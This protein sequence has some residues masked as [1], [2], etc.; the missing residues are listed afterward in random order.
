MHYINRKIESS[1]LEY[2][3]IF[4][5]LGVTGPRQSG[6]STVL[7]YLLEKDYEY[8]TFDDPK[9]I[10]FFQDDPE[11]FFKRYA[12]HII[13]DEVQKVPELF[14]YIKLKV[15]NNRSEMGQFIL[16]GSSQFSLLK[17][18]TES[19]AGRIGLLSVLPFDSQE[20]PPA[21]QTQSVYSGSYPEL[22]EKHYQYNQQWMSNYINTYIERDVRTLNNV[23]DLREFRRLLNLLATRVGTLL[24]LSE[25]ANDLGVAVNTIKRWI[26]VLE[27]SYIVFLLP[28]FYQ[29]LG[30]RLIKSPKIYFY[31][32]G[33]VS[34]LSGI[35][36]EKQFEQGPMAGNLFENFVVSDIYKQIKHNDN[37][38]Q[39]YY[40]R[41]HLKQEVDL[42][43][44]YKTHQDWLEIKKSGTFSLK[45]IKHINKLFVDAGNK[46]NKLRGY[47][48]YRGDEFIISDEIKA[49]NYLVFLQEVFNYTKD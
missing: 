32:T 24:N 7:K 21:Y 38:A 28:P 10:S 43:I 3:K 29:N 13:F 36:T 44:D 11:L 49:L 47:L 22:I 1:I 26:S 33:I 45:M 19:L 8:V 37:R 16:T 4:P 5:V 35:E 30:K 48:V 46:D 25:L 40:F 20:I 12:K 14:N 27:A 9:L 18:I 41:T 2:L 34:Y 17:Q 6:K 31:D 23:G 15:D 39:L 42:I